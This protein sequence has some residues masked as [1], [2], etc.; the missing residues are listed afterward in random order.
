MGA[1][2]GLR[3]RSGSNHSNPDSG[4]VFSDRTEYRLNV[5]VIGTDDQLREPARA[6]VPIHRQ[7]NVH[8]RLL[9]LQPPY[10]DAIAP[11]EMRTFN[12]PR[13]AD[14]VAVVGMSSH[15]LAESWSMLQLMD[16]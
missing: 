14:T 7:S 5:A 2:T 11:V 3:R 6:G 13:H 4:K 9:L 8:I 10:L 1:G 15:G 12:V 16:A